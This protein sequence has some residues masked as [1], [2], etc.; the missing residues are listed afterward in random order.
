MGRLLAREHL[1]ESV[2]KHEPADRVVPFERWTSR[3]DDW[4]PTHVHAFLSELVAVGELIEEPEKPLAIG[5]GTGRFADPLGVGFGVEPAK[6]A[7]RTARN[8][9]IQVA[10]G[11]GEALPVADEAVDLALMVTTICFLDDVGTALD[12]VARVLEPRGAFVIGFIDR[13]TPLGQAYKR[14]RSQNPFY[15][16]AVFHSASE[17]ASQLAAHG[18][19]VEAERQTLFSDPETLA[20]VDEVREG[21]GEGGFVA[22]RARL[23]EEAESSSAAGVPCRS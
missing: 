1:T 7:S 10:R 11:V 5:V 14:R 20:S 15:E 16:P 2:A 9:G 8:R 22:C 18:F 21:T 3:Y 17:V 23:Q 12:E 4:F 6:A 19:R 13:E